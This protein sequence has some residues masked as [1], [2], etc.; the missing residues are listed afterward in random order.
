LANA[1]ETERSGDLI[2]RPICQE[3][4]TTL[5]AHAKTRQRKDQRYP[6]ITDAG[7]PIARFRGLK[8]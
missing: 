2:A 5:F 7:R 4:A 1:A 3:T 8:I 6:A